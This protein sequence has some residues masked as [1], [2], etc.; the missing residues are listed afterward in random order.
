DGETVNFGGTT[1]LALAPEQSLAEADR[2]GPPAG[3]APADA[4]GT[5][6]DG[7][8]EAPLRQGE[9]EGSEAL[10]AAEDEAH[11]DLLQ[12]LA[13]GQRRLPSSAVRVRRDGAHPSYRPDGPSD[14]AGNGRLSGN[15]GAA[16]RHSTVHRR[17]GAQSQRR[18]L[19]SCRSDESTVD[20]DRFVEIAWFLSW[21]HG[22]A[23]TSR[24]GALGGNAELGSEMS[25]LACAMTVDRDWRRTHAEGHRRLA[26]ARARGGG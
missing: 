20:I 14:E 6:A 18:R 3:G 25:G 4:G 1:V 8:A 21:R 15:W 2:G 9:A 5:G 24:K 11:G 7:G 26:V 19:R 17:T 23:G 10:R 22:T 13:R 12:G 16:G